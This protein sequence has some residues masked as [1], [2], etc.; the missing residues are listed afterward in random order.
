MCLFVRSLYSF[1]RP[2]K[3]GL[4]NKGI[5]SNNARTLNYFTICSKTKTLPC[6]YNYCKKY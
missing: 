2:I 1:W 4:L 6:S 5:Y 3:D